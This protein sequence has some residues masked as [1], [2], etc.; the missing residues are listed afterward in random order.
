MVHSKSD[1]SFIVFSDVQSDC[2]IV[3]FYSLSEMTDQVCVKNAEMFL[4]QQLGE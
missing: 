3:R 2:P 4:H 1:K